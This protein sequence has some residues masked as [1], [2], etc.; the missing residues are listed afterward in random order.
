MVKTHVSYDLRCKK[1][2]FYQEFIVFLFIHH[3]TIQSIAIALMI[4]AASLILI[5]YFSKERSTTYYEHIMLE[6]KTINNK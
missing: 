6:L 2:N 1:Y 5:D 3:T 4:I